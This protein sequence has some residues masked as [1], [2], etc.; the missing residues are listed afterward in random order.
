M[1]K[2]K[3]SQ[4]AGP[5]NEGP[6]QFFYMRSKGSTRNCHLCHARENGHPGIFSISRHA[7]HP[8]DSAS[9]LRS[10]RNDTNGTVR[11][12]GKGIADCLATI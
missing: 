6:R 3:R 2:K 7:L 12:N 9:P 4:Q 5:F 1:L 11:W 10:V 8:L